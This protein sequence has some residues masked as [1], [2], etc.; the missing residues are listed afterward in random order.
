MTSP[1]NLHEELAGQVN[2]S[3]QRKR[4]RHQ[5]FHTEELRIEIPR[6]STPGVF[7]RASRRETRPQVLSAQLIDVSAQ[8]LGLRTCFSLPVG[9][10]VTI[11]GDLHSID[12]CLAFQVTSRTVHCS[13]REDGG[14]HLGLSFA[15]EEVEY[16]VLPCNHDPVFS[17]S[18]DSDW[19]TTLGST[20]A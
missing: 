5:R 8:G 14:Y 17:L 16:E 11:R 9:K 20:L 4:S 1:V 18:L 10:L 7:L 12:S 2:A 19:S 15:E 6:S 13:D 3:E